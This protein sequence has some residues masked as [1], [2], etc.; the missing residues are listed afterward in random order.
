MVCELFMD[1]KI[2]RDVIG[3]ATGRDCVAA[4]A[5]FGSASVSKRL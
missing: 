5:I 1:R 3:N 4:P 2:M